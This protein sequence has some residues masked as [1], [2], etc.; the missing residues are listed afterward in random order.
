MEWPTL[1]DDITIDNLISIPDETDENAPVYIR[2]IDELLNELAVNFDRISKSLSLLI[3][4]PEFET[5]LTKLIID[6][7]GGREGFSPEVLGVLL[8]LSARHTE[9]YGK[10]SNSTDVW[11]KTVPPR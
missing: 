1:F 2:S 6:D 4:T 8:Q 3:G 11:D 10:L 7:R 9:I 5:A